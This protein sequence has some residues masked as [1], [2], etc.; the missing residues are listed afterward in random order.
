[1]SKRVTFKHDL[2]LKYKSTKGVE[3][4]AQIEKMKTCNF[5]VCKNTI[6]NI[7]RLVITLA[8]LLA[9]RAGIFG[10]FVSSCVFGEMFLTPMFDCW[11]I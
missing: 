1:M 2:V 5:V 10:L 9:V 11:W 4:K 8:G 3:M 7:F 6:G